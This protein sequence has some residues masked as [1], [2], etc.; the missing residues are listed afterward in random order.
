MALKQL[1]FAFGLIVAVAPVPAAAKHEIPLVGAPAAGPDAQYCMRIEAITGSR[2]EKVRCW[3]RQEWA[4]QGVDVDH[5]WAEE[6]VAIIENGV[7]QIR[8]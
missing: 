8:A 2:L 4:E 5:D 1:A 7:R 3:T 6:G